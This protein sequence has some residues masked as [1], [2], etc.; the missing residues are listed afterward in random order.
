MNKQQR[1]ATKEE[2]VATTAK[3]WNC[4]TEEATIRVTMYRAGQRAGVR[5]GRAEA[6]RFLRLALGVEDPTEEE[7]AMWNNPVPLK[8]ALP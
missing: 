7:E 2:E 1:H 3:I 5:Q 4:S 6:Q 8:G